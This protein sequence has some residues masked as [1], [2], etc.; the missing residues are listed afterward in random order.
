MYQKIMQDTKEYY[1]DLSNQR[2][3]PLWGDAVKHLFKEKK[4]KGQDVSVAWLAG[5]T[6]INDKHIFNIM[7]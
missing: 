1:K 5:Q 4:A 2:K 6:G 7:A 3:A